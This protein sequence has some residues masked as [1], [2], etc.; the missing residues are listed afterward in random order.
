MAEPIVRSFVI[1]TTQAEQN[2]QRLDVVTTATNASLDGLYNQLISLDAQLQKLDPNSQAFAEVNTQIQQL[3]T[4]I[5]GIE[6]GKIDDIGKAIESID[7]GTAA[8]SIEQVGNAVEQVVAPVN[9]L[10]NATDQLNAEL[11]ETKVDTSSIEQAGSDFQELAVEQ[12][13]VTTSSK[14]LKAQL[15]ELQAQLAATDPDSAKYRELSQAAGE[16]KDRIQDAAQAVGTQAGGAF[17]RVSGSLGLVTS[18]IANLDFEGAAEGAKLLAQNITQIKPGDIAKGIQGIGSAFASIGKALLT[19]PIFLIGAAIAAAIVY[20]DE[21]L[22]LID[23]VTDAETKALDA[24]KERAALAKEQVDLISSQE[25]QL[26][27]Q[28]KTEKEITALKLQ[29]LDTA[30]LEQQ[31]VV[32]TTRIQA[33]G[34]IKAAERNAK[35][36]QTFLDFVTFPQRKL[37]EF[38]QNFVNGSIE[39]LNKLGLGIEKIDVTGVFDDI[40]NFVVK[41]VFDPAAERKNQ[42]QIVKDAEKSLNQLNE[43]R[44]GIINSQNAKEI[45]NAKKTADERLK[46]EQD[47]NKQILDARKKIFEESQKL[48]EA[49]R[50]DAAKPIETKDVKIVGNVGIEITDE[51]TK[52]IEDKIAKE[53]ALLSDARDLEISLMAEGQDK[54]IALVDAKYAKLREQAQG[55][56]D[57]Q[58]QITQ[59]NIDEVNAIIQAGVDKETAIRQAGFKKGLDLAQG[60]IQVLQAFSDASTKKGERDAKKKFKTDKA[61]AIGA[62]TVQTASAVTGAL[63]AGGNP[64]K[65]ATGAQ[66]VEAALAAALGLAQIV[67]IKNSQFGGGSTGGNDTPPSVP[68]TGGG[69]GTTGSQPA[70]FNPLASSFLQ[71]RP[72][73]L[74][75]RAYVLSGDV[76]SQQEVR[77]KVEDL[78]RIG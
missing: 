69:G 44:A 50:K 20:A 53:K 6:T 78:A 17:E 7:A 60:A 40:N 51:E 63:T 52:A 39:V 76:A 41:S 30:I 62:A 25:Q 35:Y 36:L 37:A 2:L 10:A 33:E 75:P 9:N 21:L 4:T 43:Q 65:L 29:A 47:L 67:K 72:E 24:Q 27:L 13:E 57:L 1:D 42:E 19:N 26:K 46:I 56:A 32:E 14:S 58:K 48:N 55:N 3:E 12:E 54:E 15:R 49:I 71:D 28:G 77:T 18:R 31:A 34:Q 23:G 22:S 64:I 70:Q 5:T 68:S 61:L 66:F 16:L 38:F 45:A 73:Q 11:K 8:Q 59:Q 74:T